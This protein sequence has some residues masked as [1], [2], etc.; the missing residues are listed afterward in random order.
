MTS[1]RLRELR[2]IS[3]AF[4]GDRCVPT[5]LIRAS[6]GHNRRCVTEPAPAAL[7][8]PTARRA[9]DRR[10]A[11]IAVPALGSLVAEPLYLLVD[12]FIVGHLGRQQLAALGI[13][14]QLLLTIVGLCVFLAY[15]TTTEVAR[16]AD[17]R[18][19]SALGV[20]GLWLGAAVGLV[21]AIVLLT[22]SGP[23][24]DAI[25][26]GGETSDLGAR[27][28]RLSAVGVAA[29]LVAIAGQGWLRG[30]EQL[31]VALRLVLIGQAVNLVAEVVL[32]YGAGLGLDGSA[33]GTV[34]AQLSMAGATIALVLRSARATDA[35]LRPGA[36][37]LAHLSRFGGLLLIRS[38][39]LSGAYLVVGGFAARISDG[40][41]GAHQIAMQLL[42]L[43]AL[44]LDALA[45]AA[46]VLV[47]SALG[48]RD[49]G[50]ARRAA[51]RVT[52]ISAG[53]GV[54]VGALLAV[55]GPTAVVTLFSPDFSPDPAIAAAARELWPW[56][57]AIQLVG[58][59]VFALDGILIGAND[60]RVLA[61]SMVVA[62]AVL[63]VS[64]FATGTS[65]LHALWI[66]IL[67]MFFARGAALGLRALRGPLQVVP[68]ASVA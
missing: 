38:I 54:L 61:G 44:A 64:L 16:A 40:A 50:A 30:R 27:Y 34:I 19:R 42:W 23:I 15:G 36:A 28:L 13:S 52:M 63:Y 3:G 9:L 62:A 59:I 20:Q 25:G 31:R 24:A 32:V 5:P 49:P 45:I 21:V 6:T 8:A 11:A 37:T 67:A 51:A 58:G 12:T 48:A 10:I 46:Q 41:I 14:M 66:A 1:T 56:L 26:G 47:A 53:F 68:A 17:E 18:S 7:P 2:H 65:S 33:L 39:A 4:K 29:Q 57:C 35:P 22:L 43:G 60:G 55:I